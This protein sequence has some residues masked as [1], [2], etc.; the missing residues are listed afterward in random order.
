MCIIYLSGD[1]V[2]CIYLE[3][4]YYVSIWK[5]CIIYLSGEGVLY[6]Y[7]NIYIY[8]E[9]CISGEGG[10]DLSIYIYL[11]LL[12][13]APSI[14]IQPEKFFLI[15]LIAD[16]LLGPGAGAAH[17]ARH[18]ARPGLR[19]TVGLTH[20]LGRHGAINREGNT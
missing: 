13:T 14:W 7:I 16:G 17:Q 4:V 10:E 18:G 5:W 6:I 8:L 3:M 20:R 1:G 2:L 12:L 19:H 11:L 9:N 15:L